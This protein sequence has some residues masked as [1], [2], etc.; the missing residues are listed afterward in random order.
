MLLTDLYKIKLGVFMN[1]T[2]T[3]FSNEDLQKIYKERE[4]SRER[5]KNVSDRLMQRQEIKRKI[6]KD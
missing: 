2:K 1:V 3:F 4:S 6:M 5:I